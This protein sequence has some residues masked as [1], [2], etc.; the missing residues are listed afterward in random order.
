MI[1]IRL[2]RKI[3]DKIETKAAEIVAKI[4]V[5]AIISIPENKNKTVT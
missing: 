5:D 2:I 4:L 1:I 3:K